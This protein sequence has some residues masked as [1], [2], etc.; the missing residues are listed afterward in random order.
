MVVLL[1]FIL[2]LFPLPLDQ[3]G[4]SPCSPV[5]HTMPP[6]SRIC[7]DNFLYSWQS[8]PCLYVSP[9]L[10]CFK[11]SHSEIP[12]VRTSTAVLGETIQQVRGNALF[13]WPCGAVAQAETPSE[14]WVHLECS[15]PE[16]EAVT[17]LQRPPRGRHRLQ[18]HRHHLRREARKMALFSFKRWQ[19][20]LESVWRCRTD[21]LL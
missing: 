12:G 1:A 3:P 17:V 2:P 15:V 9:Y 18:P 5:W 20:M 13:V 4:A 7:G 10:M 8:F 16:G 11:W 21:E 14:L 19:I 6:F